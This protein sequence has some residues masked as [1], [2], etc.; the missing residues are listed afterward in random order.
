MGQNGRGKPYRVTPIL[1]QSKMDVLLVTG[2]C[3]AVNLAENGIS[4]CGGEG[5]ELG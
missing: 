2:N 5:G 4:R 1:F 3:H